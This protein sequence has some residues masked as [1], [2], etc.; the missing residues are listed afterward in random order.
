VFSGE[1]LEKSPF[2]RGQ[3]FLVKIIYG[4]ENLKY[5]A[6]LKDNI[7]LQKALFKLKK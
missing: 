5:Y 3:I 1:N 2:E 7:L 4:L 6:F